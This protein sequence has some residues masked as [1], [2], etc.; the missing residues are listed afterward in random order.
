[1]AQDLVEVN[2]DDF[3]GVGQLQRF[4]DHAGDEADKYDRADEYKMTR[5]D[6]LVEMNS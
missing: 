1:M 3:D 6:V 4:V 5:P 2:A